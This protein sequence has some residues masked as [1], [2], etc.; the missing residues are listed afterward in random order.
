M[1]R[2]GVLRP[3]CQCHSPAHPAGDPG[4]IAPAT[5]VVWLGCLTRK[6]SR[7]RGAALRWYGRRRR[8]GAVMV[9]RDKRLRYRAPARHPVAADYRSFGGGTGDD[10]PVAR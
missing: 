5:V 7:Q 10:W 9:R 6:H 3:V 2:P 8:T 4:C 1:T